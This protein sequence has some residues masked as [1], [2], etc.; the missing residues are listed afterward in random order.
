MPYKCLSSLTSP[1]ST[2]DR[3]LVDRRRQKSAANPAPLT[4]SQISEA[5][6]NVYHLPSIVTWG[7]DAKYIFFILTHK[8]PKAKH[9]P[10][11]G[12][13]RS[14]IRQWANRQ[15]EKTAHPIH[16]YINTRCVLT[17]IN[18]TSEVTW[19]RRKH[20][21]FASLLVAISL[22]L[23]WSFFRSLMYN[24]YEKNGTRVGHFNTGSIVSK[25]WIHSALKCLP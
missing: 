9:F 22:V 4:R 14:A 18:T 21:V 12:L 2:W 7:W 17:I 16:I 23:S 5:S 19:R 11:F 8:K 20:C 24:L 13:L 25:M 10:P 15:E 3:F 6:T 1:T